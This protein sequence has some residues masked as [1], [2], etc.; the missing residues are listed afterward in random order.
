MN[1]GFVTIG[2][3]VS[4][5]LHKCLQE[6][7]FWKPFWAEHWAGCSVSTIVAFWP[8]TIVWDNVIYKICSSLY[9]CLPQILFPSLFLF[10]TCSLLPEKFS[11]P[12][13][14]PQIILLERDFPSPTLCSSPVSLSFFSFVLSKGQPEIERTPFLYCAYHFPFQIHYLWLVM[15]IFAC[16]GYGVLFSPVHPIYVSFPIRSVSSAVIFHWC[17]ILCECT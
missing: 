7:P 8:R 6:S 15:A 1:K 12:T 5:C 9:F 13:E 11:F 17:C 14:C 16:S 3:K 2:G 4:G 10:Q